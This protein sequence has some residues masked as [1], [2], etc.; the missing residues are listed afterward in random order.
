MFHSHADILLVFDRPLSDEETIFAE[1]TCTNSRGLVD[2]L[3]YTFKEVQV[4][5]DLGS[6]SP[7]RYRKTGP[8]LP[9]GQSKL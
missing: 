8:P 9:K 7:E 4:M 1:S 2:H 3:G 6:I 5:Q